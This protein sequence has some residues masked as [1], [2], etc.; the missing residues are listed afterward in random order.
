MS[1][2]NNQEGDDPELTLMTSRCAEARER[3]AVV[4]GLCF[5]VV[6]DPAD[7]CR[8]RVEELASLIP[9]SL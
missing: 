5:P 3:D 9:W 2:M 4:T 7:L 1:G 8:V 6:P